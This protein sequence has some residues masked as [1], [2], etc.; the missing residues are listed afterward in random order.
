MEFEY[1]EHISHPV[2]QVF[3]TI[4]DHLTVLIPR[5]DGVDAIE[6]LSRDVEGTTTRITNLW[7][8]NSASAPAPARPFVTKKMTTWRDHAVWHRDKREVHWRFETLYFDKL[9]DCSGIHYFSDEAN[10]DGSEGAQ[11]RITGNLAVYPGRVPGVPK[12]VA[13]GVAPMIE[14]FLIDMVSPNLKELPLAV[15]AHLDEAQ[16]AA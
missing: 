1:V 16:G 3:E 8:G 14:Q 15:Q 9:Y 10:K 13:R 6:E 11:L 5:I 7:H 4:R 2:D 12:L